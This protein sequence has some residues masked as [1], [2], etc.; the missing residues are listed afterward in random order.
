MPLT[1]IQSA[2]SETHRMRAGEAFHL[3]A[4]PMPSVSKRWA[5]VVE[6][7][8]FAPKRK[9]ASVKAIC[10]SERWFVNWLYCHS[11]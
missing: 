11:G 1:A 8:M 3:Q 9:Q 2:W 10:L 5:F 7:L 6:P 4:Y